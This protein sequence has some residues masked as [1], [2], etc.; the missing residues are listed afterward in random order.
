MEEEIVYADVSLPVQA[1]SSRNLVSAQDSDPRPCPR[2]QRIVMWSG[3]AGNI[4]LVAAVIAMGV[5]G[6]NKNKEPVWESISPSER[7]S[8]Y[9]YG[10]IGG[11]GDRILADF[12]SRLK[13]DLC[14][15]STSTENGR[16]RLCPLM[17]KLNKDKCYWI[18]S[19]TQSWE[20]SNKDCEAKRSQLLDGSELEAEKEFIQKNTNAAVWIGLHFLLPRHEWVWV[21][22]SPLNLTQ[23]PD[24]PSEKDDCGTL[25]G[26][27]INHEKCSQDLHWICQKKSVLI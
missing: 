8:S 21:N 2:W 27:K 4:I 3:L 16:C 5:W 18:S 6:R 14:V 1:S 11:E 12:K 20:K 17:W 7:I 19:T 13:E 24:W 10:H 22:G 25:K 23:Y 26:N 15:N 9:Q